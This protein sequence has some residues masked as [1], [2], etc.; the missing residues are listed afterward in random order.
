MC[1]VGKRC[2]QTALTTLSLLQPSWGGA[3]REGSI[4][5]A[6]HFSGLSGAVG[7]EGHLLVEKICR[8][9]GLVQVD[10]ELSFHA[11]MPVD[12]PPS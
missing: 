3:R 11:E 10:Q 1:R 9:R 12:F 6:S 8:G 5:N 2:A 4:K 7:D